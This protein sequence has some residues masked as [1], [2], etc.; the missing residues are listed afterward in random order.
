[1][2][3]PEE[4]LAGLS[5][6]QLCIENS[7]KTTIRNVGRYKEY[8]DPKISYSLATGPLPVGNPPN[9]KVPNTTYF[10]MVSGQFRYAIDFLPLLTK[11]TKTGTNG[12]TVYVIHLIE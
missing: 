4:E 11:A 6:E 3:S 8:G 5:V 12:G 7:L 1:M 2:I 10:P 9:I